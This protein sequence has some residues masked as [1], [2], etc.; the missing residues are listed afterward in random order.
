MRCRTG[1]EIVSERMAGE[2]AAFPT[3]VAFALGFHIL[4]DEER[5]EQPVWF[6]RQDVFRVGQHR[7]F[8]GAIE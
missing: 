1:R 8:A 7:L 4:L 6:E 3:A 5:G 2:S